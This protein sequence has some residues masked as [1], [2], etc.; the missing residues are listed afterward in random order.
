LLLKVQDDLG[1]S[2]GCNPADLGASRPA[3]AALVMKGFPLFGVNQMID[4]PV[5]DLVDLLA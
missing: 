2:L 5:A 4:L 3:V 1:G